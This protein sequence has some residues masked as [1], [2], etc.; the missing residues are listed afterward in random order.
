MKPFLRRLLITLGALVILLV[1]FHLVENWRGRQAWKQWKR[2]REAAGDFN[3]TA[4]IPPEVPDAENFARAPRIAEFIAPDPKIP[5]P[6]LPI[7][8]AALSESGALGDWKMAQT[9]DLEG[10]KSNLKVKDLKEVLAPW[11]GELAALSEAAQ[12]P[13][14]RLLESYEGMDTIPALLGLRARARMLTLRALISLREKRTDAALEDVITG[15]RVAGH[16][17]KEPHLISQLLRT[18]YVNILMQPIW[19][20][21]QDH[22]WSG[23]HLQKLQEALSPIDLVDSFARGWRGE[24]IYGVKS[25]ETI[26]DASLWSRPQLLGY[27]EDHEPSRMQA[28]LWTAIFPKGWVYQNLLRID[29]HYT[30]QFLDVFDPTNHRINASASRKAA[31]AME[32]TRRGPYTMLAKISTPALSG[33]NL[34]VA[35]AQS[36]L[37]LAILACALERHRLEKG[38]YPETLTALV[39][40]YLPKSPV[41]VVEGQNLRYA[42]GREGFTLYSLG[43]N[44]TDEGG[45]VPPKGSENQGDWVWS[46]GH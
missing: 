14:C 35:R 36:A 20:G 26:A 18:A 39:P 38:R 46:K 6:S 2:A 31:E 10:L 13:H 19:E 9:A 5:S 4:L 17:Q 22:R 27:T 1:I 21:I 40:A 25:M 3:P 44:L 24:R 37:D 8:P 28:L 30:T 41:D 45:Q 33:Q 12:R 32:Q 34:R 29:Q 16:L 15:L 23:T 11:E 43:W 7:L 42:P